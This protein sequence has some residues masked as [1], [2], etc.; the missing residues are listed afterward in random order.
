M[1]NFRSIKIESAIF[2]SHFQLSLPWQRSSIVQVEDLVRIQQFSKARYQ[3]QTLTAARL[4]VHED[5]QG[6]HIRGNHAGFNVRQQQHQQLLI[7]DNRFAQIVEG[8]N[9]Q[10]E[11]VIY[12]IRNRGLKSTT[13]RLLRILKGEHD[14]TILIVDGSDAG[15][16][17]LIG[18]IFV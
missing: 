7:L 10:S 8:T 6:P 9:L 5:Q 17:V 3:L 1:E 16:L 12:A 2:L 14:R 13:Y 4:D 15:E 18:H 11:N